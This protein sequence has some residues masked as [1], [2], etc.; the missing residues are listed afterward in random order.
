M[1]P[2]GFIKVFRRMFTHPLFAAS[3]DNPYCKG[4]AW[5]DLIRRASYMPTIRL[6][7]GHQVT[8]NIGDV[9]VSE[10]TLEKDWHWT[11]SK[12]R[13]FLK[14]LEKNHMITR[15]TAH[16]E[17]I[18][19]IVNYGKYNAHV[20]DYSPAADPPDGPSTAQLPPTQY[21]EEESK[22]GKEMK[23]FSP[24]YTP[25]SADDSPRKAGGRGRRGPAE[26]PAWARWLAYANSMGW[27][28]TREIREGFNYYNGRKWQY[29][30]G[31]PVANWR[32]ACENSMFRAYD[33]AG[34]ACHA[35]KKIF[36]DPMQVPS[37]WS[38]EYFEITGISDIDEATTWA[39][40]IENDPEMALAII[41][42]K[43][44]A[45]GGRCPGT[46]TYRDDSGRDRTEIGDIY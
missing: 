36:L 38:W 7:K 31:S 9:H 46:I 39:K 15:R 44:A 41:M 32:S 3:K 17:G 16:Q 42:R 33:R 27:T 11:R 19:N 37:G 45:N 18:I 10:R 26:G 43:K 14:T 25:T 22:E 28:A 4:F 29:S 2:E 34:R 23:E 6:V 12:V 20:Y 21:N 8:L 24:P 30:D 13:E 1:T 35:V 40:L 5:Q